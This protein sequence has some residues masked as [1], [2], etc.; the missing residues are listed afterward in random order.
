MINDVSAMRPYLF[1]QARMGS[2]RLPGKVLSSLNNTP[3][4]Q[5]LI[6][7]L[8]CLDLP[9]CILTTDQEIDDSIESFCAKQAKIKCFRGDE[10]NVAKRFIDAAIY[11]NC[12]HFF[13]LTGDNPFVS[14]ELIRSIYRYSQHKKLNYLSFPKRATLEGTRP[15]YMSLNALKNCYKENH[16]NN[17]FT[18]HVTPILYEVANIE[19]S[20][21]VPRLDFRHCYPIISNSSVTIDTKEDHDSLTMFLKRLPQAMIRDLLDGRL[22][23][24]TICYESSFLCSLL[25]KRKD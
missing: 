11:L 25:Q 13:R 3:L 9:I 8:H 1:I 24:E 23:I 2:T 10:H 18:E 21:L 15:E 17:Y 5:I 7:R 6:N 19:D 14:I 4:L 12:N 22:D 20:L 16:Q